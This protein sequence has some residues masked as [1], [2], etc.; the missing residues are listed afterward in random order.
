VYC[1]YISHLKFKNL[2]KKKQPN[3]SFKNSFISCEESK[4]A[5]Q[6]KN[7]ELQKSIDASKEDCQK[8][9]SAL[10]PQTQAT[11]SNNTA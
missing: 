9:I 7:E 4:V 8:Q 5:L 1:L 11:K 2:F 10:K 3:Y 6:S